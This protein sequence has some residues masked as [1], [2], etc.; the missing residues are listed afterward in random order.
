LDI[1]T[2]REEVSYESYLGPRRNLEA[3]VRSRDTDDAT[4]PE[5]DFIEAGLNVDGPRDP[6]TVSMP[7]PKVGNSIRFVKRRDHPRSGRSLGSAVNEIIARRMN[8]K[9]QMRWNRTTVHSFLDVR[10]AVLNDKVED[11]FRHHYQGFRP[12]NDDMV[13]SEAP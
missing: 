10:T 8:K 5:R 4:R 11:A 3:S 1:E 9:P 7:Q 2:S 13:L 12:T 6:S